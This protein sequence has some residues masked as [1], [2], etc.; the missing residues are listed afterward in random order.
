[1]M[2]AFV[3]AGLALA[4]CGSKEKPPGEWDTFTYADDGFSVRAPI[5]PGESTE[6]IPTEFGNAPTRQYACSKLTDEGAL[7][8]MA[9]DVDLPGDLDIPA[10]LK[11]VASATSGGVNGQMISSEA[12][13]LGGAPGHRYEVRGEAPDLGSV[14]MMGVAYYHNKRLYQVMAMYPV[15]DAKYKEKGEAFLASFTFL[16]GD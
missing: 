3:V 6:T 12:V 15:G 11:D 9:S 4:A 13:T 5:K 2:I 7:I 16:A 14:E 1:M 8:V 10:S